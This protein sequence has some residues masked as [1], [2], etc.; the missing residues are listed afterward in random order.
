MF[1]DVNGTRRNICCGNIYVMWGTVQN[2][3]GNLKTFDDSSNDYIDNMT[4]YKNKRDDILEQGNLSC[5]E[6]RYI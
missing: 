4:L 6:I 1:N 3:P 5:Y 2:I